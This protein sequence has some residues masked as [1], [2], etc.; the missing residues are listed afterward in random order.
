MVG[1]VPDV[2]FFLFF[3]S[4]LCLVKCWHRLTS[5]S[6]KFPFV[7]FPNFFLA[8]SCCPPLSVRAMPVVGIHAVSAPNSAELAGGAAVPDA[9]VQEICQLLGTFF[10][11]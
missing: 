2:F 11:F 6:P 7:N 1:D 8:S 4:L 10:V 9:K 5:F 3:F